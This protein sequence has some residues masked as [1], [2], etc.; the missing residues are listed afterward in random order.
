ML[1]VYFGAVQNREQVFCAD[2]LFEIY[3]V[4]LFDCRENDERLCQRNAARALYLVEQRF[5]SAGRFGVDFEKKVEVA[6]DVVTLGYLL[7]GLDEF[8]EIVVV[9]RMLHAHRDE[10]GDVHAELLAVEHDGVL[11]DYAVGFE[12]LY[13]LDNGR[14]GH[15]D[16]RADYR[17]V[18]SCVFLETFDYLNIYLVQDIIPCAAVCA[19]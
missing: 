12:L 17:S 14:D 6:G 3:R 5:K 10:R 1:S 15:V 19:A 9:L 7:V 2:I 18:F 13:A 4:V 8:V 16:L 11:L